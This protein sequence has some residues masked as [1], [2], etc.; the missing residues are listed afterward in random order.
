MIAF[1]SELAVVGWLMCF[2]YPLI[3]STLFCYIVALKH[4]TDIAVIPSF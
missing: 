2:R 3:L 4:Q 1:S